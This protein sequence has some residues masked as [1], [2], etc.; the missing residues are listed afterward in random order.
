M[1]VAWI[2]IATLWTGP[3]FAQTMY[4]CLDGQR[5]TTYSNIT[6]EKQG[7]N[8]AGT[9]EERVTSMPF[10]PPQKPNQLRRVPDSAPAPA[11]A[12][13][14]VAP[15]E[16]EAGGPGGGARVKPVV[17]LIEKLVK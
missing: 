7:L 16:A 4:K 6:C 12:P 3:G 14:P 8:A 15:V 5:R 13:P 1:R 11:D 2:L 10:T 9:V 17:P